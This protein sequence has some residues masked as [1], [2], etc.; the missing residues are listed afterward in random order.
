MEED[1]KKNQMDYLSSLKFSGDYLTKFINEIL[2]INK[3]D[4]N[5]SEIEYTSFNLKKL[6]EDIKHS[7]KELAVVNNNNF[8]L[9]VNAAIPDYLI[10]DPTKLS[11]IIMNLIN[12][13]LK[14][15]K[16][17][18]VTVITNLETLED[19][20]ATLYFEITDTGIGIPEDKLVTVFDSFSYGSTEVNR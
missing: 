18:N 10:V 14:F 16:N 5:K 8:N 1:P 15:T 2:E 17:G 7:L 3:I 11:Q 19:K 6:L 12:N 20:K 13:A 4:S 9:E